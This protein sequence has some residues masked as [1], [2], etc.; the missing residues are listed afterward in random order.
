MK[1]SSLALGL[2]VALALSALCHGLG[3]IYINKIVPNDGTTAVTVEK[4][5][6]QN[7]MMM[8]DNMAGL[9]SPGGKSQGVYIE[10]VNFVRGNVFVPHDLTVDQV[11][12]FTGA[13]HADGS[14]T[15]D[16]AP[17]T[18]NSFSVEDNSGLTTILGQTNANGGI[19]VNNDT[20][21]VEDNT[22]RTTIKSALLRPNG[23]TLV[24][25]NLFKISGKDGSITSKGEVDVQ[26][27]VILGTS[28]A[29]TRY[30]TRVPSTSTAPGM[31]GKERLMSLIGQNG[32]SQGG[33]L[34]LSP[35]VPTGALGETQFV[36]GKIVVGRASNDDLTLDRQSVAAAAGST[37]YD[38]QSSVD[39]DSQG[40]D[41]LLTA[42]S[43]AT[44]GD[45]L[46]RVGQNVNSRL[47]NGEILLGSDASD[48]MVRRLPLTRQQD[49]RTL[50]MRG[51]A[52]PATAPVGNGGKISFKAGDGF[53]D[54]RPGD[55]VLTP[56]HSAPGTRLRIRLGDAVLNTA[57][58][59]YSTDTNTDLY[60]TRAATT[61]DAGEGTTLTPSS[62][63]NFKGQ[64]S[65]QGTG[66][67][68]TFRAGDASVN[69]FDLSTFTGGS[70]SL[71][72][73]KWSGPVV[74]KTPYIS[75]IYWGRTTQE[76]AIRR[77]NSTLTSGTATTISGQNVVTTIATGYGG[78]LQFFAG[79]STATGTLK[80][81]GDITIRTPDATINDVGGGGNVAL[82]TPSFVFV[83]AGKGVAGGD[84]TIQSGS[85]TTAGDIELTAVTNT[86][87]IAS[88]TN[89]I[90]SPSFTTT[91]PISYNP[92]G[93]G[94]KFN[95]VVAVRGASRLSLEEVD[96]KVTSAAS[97]TPR[98]VLFLR[99][100]VAT[101]SLIFQRT[102][103]ADTNTLQVPCDLSD[104]TTLTP[105][106]CTKVASTD[107]HLQV[108]VP[109]DTPTAF[110][111]TYT[112]L[113]AAGRVQ[114]EPLRADAFPYHHIFRYV[115]SPGTALPT[116]TVFD[117]ILA[118]RYDGKAF[119]M[120]DA[121]TTNL[122]HLNAL[123][124]FSL[125]APAIQ[126]HQ[127]YDPPVTDAE[128]LSKLAGSGTPPITQFKN[129]PANTKI[130]ARSPAIP[131]PPYNVFQGA[132]TPQGR[133]TSDT[134]LPFPEGIATDGLAYAKSK[135]EKSYR[136]I[137]F[138]L[139][140]NMN[141]VICAL[142]NIGL[143]QA[144]EDAFWQT[145]GGVTL[146]APRNGGVIPGLIPKNARCD[147]TPLRLLSYL[148]N[149]NTYY[150]T[151]TA[152]KFL[153]PVYTA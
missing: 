46:L 42:G 64:S 72:T 100:N 85:G 25:T 61:S 59:G 65:Y 44:T 76:L 54:K 56:G 50:F 126:R 39:A 88:G 53:A 93:T 119:H 129:F 41:M 2:L 74:T 84:V 49:A 15:A 1:A 107:T 90:L 110:Q 29:E 81:A 66:G 9:N 132:T 14:L 104:S 140:L 7:N 138:D 125:I 18:G 91:Q 113:N 153:A 94:P 45:L 118:P 79:T 120:N 96:F 24:R 16:A 80:R 144:N 60:V 122:Y 35:G 130:S 152:G 57:K 103:G 127:F 43:G 134:S 58:P 116:G 99:K 82:S 143:I 19:A 87:N 32:I 131:I 27:D 71:T 3:T 75:H 21:T 73:G 89:E 8:V 112:T 30:I 108:T 114:L 124:R 28:T 106:G 23:D 40:G 128:T 63:T 48:L 69:R 26:K 68:I 105:T 133:S 146:P 62:R 12:T 97:T 38:G 33:S 147:P 139:A 117:T 83:S 70:L 20:F 31:A 151:T 55:V 95:G 121:V 17:T 123:P 36:N 78:D 92:T 111:P 52:Q 77:Y 67:A 86:N 149:S 109:V 22:G 98:P 13:L 47:L 141:R 135:T 115:P 51:Q 137:L 10:D 142:H 101:T 5:Q 145:G 4:V 102:T 34:V 37:T 136:G 11:A 6:F 150:T 148:A